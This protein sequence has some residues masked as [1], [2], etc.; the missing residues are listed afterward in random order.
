MNVETSTTE[1]G[2][3]VPNLSIYFWRFCFPYLTKLCTLYLLYTAWD[4]KMAFWEHGL[5]KNTGRILLHVVG[6]FTW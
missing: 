6:Y 3:I 5:R 1:Q 2:F 4:K